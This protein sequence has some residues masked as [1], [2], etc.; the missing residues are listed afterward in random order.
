MFSTNVCFPPVSSFSLT[1]VLVTEA[2]LP[3]H[4]LQNIVLKLPSHLC[5]LYTMSKICIE[6]DWKIII[7]FL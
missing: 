6:K 5:N 4:I 1:S 3:G 2:N 7:A